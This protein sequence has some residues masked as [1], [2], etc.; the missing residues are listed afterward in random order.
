MIAP[1]DSAFPAAS[2]VVCTRNRSSLLGEACEAIL[3]IDPP[4]GGWEL[5]IIDN[6]ST[7]DTRD[8]AKSVRRRAPELVTVIDEPTVGLSAARNRGFAESRGSVVAFIDD[9]AFPEPTWLVSLM[10]AF[11]DQDVASAGGPVEPIFEGDLPPWFQGRYLGYLT[12]WNPGSEP[13]DL[14]YNEYPRGANMAFRRDLVPRFGGFS[15]HLGRKANSLLSCEE[16]EFCLRF[17][18]GGLRSVFI[19]EARVRHTTPVSRLTPEWMESRFAAQGQS[20]AIID[21]MHGGIRGLLRGHSAHRGRAREA[22]RQELGTDDLFRRCQVRA[23][24]GYRRGMVAAPITIRRYAPP[25][26]S[27]NLTPWPS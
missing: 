23:L 24:R 11:D 5:L 1:M 16:T 17:E 4:D 15:T 20:E 7:D 2:V 26:K 12:V 18:R 8:V 3:G 10:E 19:P 14:T 22:T 25:D 13:F 6:G 27:I 9:D 21:W